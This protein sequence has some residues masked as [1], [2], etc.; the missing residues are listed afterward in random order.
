MTSD[1]P[2]W[3]QN[4]AAVLKRLLQEIGLGLG[5]LAVATLVLLPSFW[6]IHLLFLEGLGITLA[7]VG[8]FGV[9]FAVYLA[10]R[11]DM[12]FPR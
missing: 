5:T 10:Y 11:S 1:M 4:G 6:I 3:P 8:G 12:L 7:V 2:P 9:A